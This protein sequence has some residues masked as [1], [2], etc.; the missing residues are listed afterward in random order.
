MHRASLKFSLFIFI[1]VVVLFALFYRLGSIAYLETSEARYAEMSREMLER[2][3]WVTPHQSYIKH[4]DKPPLTYWVTATAFKIFGFN[5][6]AGRIPLALTALFILCYTWFLSLL[7]FPDRR[8]QA[9]FSVL[10]LFGSPL[11]LAMSR[12][13]TTDLYLALFTLGATYHLLRWFLHDRRSSD[14]FLSALFLGCGILTKGHVI[15]IF[16]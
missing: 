7:L 15:F 16:Y 5:D 2:G 4:F 6:W 11:F 8:E 3:D 10:V 13:L 1:A 12:T 14:A 9:A